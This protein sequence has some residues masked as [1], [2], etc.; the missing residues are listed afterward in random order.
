MTEEQ[1]TRIIPLLRAGKLMV[2]R[3]PPWKCPHCGVEIFTFEWQN[4]GEVWKLTC[5]GEDCGE[6][7]YA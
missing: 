3:K 5:P 2:M 6:V 4:D 7:F 1:I